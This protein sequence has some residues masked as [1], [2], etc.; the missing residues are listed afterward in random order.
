MITLY[1]FERVVPQVIGHTRDLRAQ[2]VLEECGLPYRVHGLDFFEGDLKSSEYHRINAFEQV[3][4]IDDDG[5]IVAESAAVVLYVAE[6]SGKLIPADFLG[7]TRVTQ[8]CFVAMN[9]VEPVLLQIAAIDAGVDDDANDRKRRPALV[10]LANRRFSALE[11]RL[12]GQ[13]YLADD[14]FSAADLLMTTVLRELR[15]T[16]LLEEY[17]RIK[18]YVAYCED[19]PAWQRT[20]DAYEQ[21]LH[22]APG[23]T[24]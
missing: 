8:W 22:A 20:L 12:S 10:N 7:R 23:S 13:G 14:E 6:K 19:R 21:R 9:S 17:P 16:D 11:E 15:T 5:F 24:R 3:P 18:R 1:G 2:W 4:V